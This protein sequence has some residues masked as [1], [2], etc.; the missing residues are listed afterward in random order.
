M[1]KEYRYVRFDCLNKDV[2]LVSEYGDVYSVKR[3]IFLK[4]YLDK[5][6]YKKTS[7]Q[8]KNGQRLSISIHRLVAFAFLGDPDSSMISPTVDHID[9]NKLNN[10]YTNLRWRERSV[11]SSERKCTAYGERN[12]CAVL[13][14]QEVLE[15]C[16]YLQDT[17]MSLEQIGNMYNV[18]KSTISNIKRRKRW[19]YLSKDFVFAIRKQ[20]NKEEAAKQRREIAR[21]FS[22]GYNQAQITRLGYP[23]TCVSRTKRKLGLD[24]KNTA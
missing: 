21:L 8:M 19:Q 14:E 20:K 18:D 17:D 9:G 4:T 22:C 13:K 23:R 12:G 2:Y 7:L 24:V 10:H 3:K 11:N 6:G 5:D 15:I 16:G 1:V